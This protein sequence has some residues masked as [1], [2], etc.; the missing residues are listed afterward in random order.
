M[1]TLSRGFACDNRD[2]G[3]V[4]GFVRYEI[5]HVDEFGYEYVDAYYCDMCHDEWLKR[6]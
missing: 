3:R 5:Y 2:D 6:K 4:H 1:E